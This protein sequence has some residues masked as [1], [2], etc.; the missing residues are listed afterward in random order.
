MSVSGDRFT[1]EIRYLY[2]EHGAI[3]GIAAEVWMTIVQL[4]ASHADDLTTHQKV[5][6]E[7][8]RDRGFT[9]RVIMTIKT[10]EP[11]AMEPIRLASKPLLE[12]R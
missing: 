9:L 6:Y 2:I 11:L 10:F 12:L 8:F 3:D 5:P 1:R 7:G 4:V